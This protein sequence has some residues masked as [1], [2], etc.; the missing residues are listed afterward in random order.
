MWPARHVEN[1][2]RAP[3]YPRCV[4]TVARISLRGDREELHGWGRL[5][6]EL[7][8]RGELVDAA[9]G[10]AGP[11]LAKIVTPAGKSPPVVTDGHIRS[12]PARR[13][14]ERAVA[15]EHGPQAEAV[16]RDDTLILLFMCCHPALTPASAIALT[17]RAVG[18]LTTMEIANA[19]LVPEAS[20]RDGRRHHR[21]AG[22]PPGRGG[23]HHQHPRTA[24]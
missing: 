11:D 4:R 10:L 22:P 13:R 19:F 6:K 14:R 18:G 2:R 15:A 24:D 1:G 3:S 23:P 7:I 17:L 9:H 8:N 21:R 12:E 16:H 5:D 20:V